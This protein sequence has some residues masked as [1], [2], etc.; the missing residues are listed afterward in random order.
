MPLISING[1]N[2][3]FLHFGIEKSKNPSVIFIHGAGQSSVCWKFQYKLSE[4]LGHFNFI[5]IDLPGH[6]KS[7]GFGFRSVKE[8]SDF[9][10]A[11]INKMNIVGYVLIGHSMGGRISQVNL[12]DYP[13][14]AIG[15]V[16]AGTGTRIRITKYTMAI[17]KNSIKDF[18]E[19]AADNSFSKMAAIELKTEFKSWLLNSRQ[20][21]IIND[22]TACY[23]FD[24][25]EEILGINVPTYYHCRRRR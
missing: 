7:E 15:S 5:F 16:L 10:N 19:L 13:D 17:T 3:Y 1:I 24:T 23:E 8:Y 18:A 25:T 6:G 2:T 20:E 14:H 12:L 21:T 4:I 9:L 11:F 22:L